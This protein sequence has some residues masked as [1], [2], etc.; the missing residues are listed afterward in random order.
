MGDGQLLRKFH[1]LSSSL[2]ITGTYLLS[3]TT[4]KKLKSNLT[5]Q[6]KAYA[7]DELIQRNASK[8]AIYFTFIYSILEKF[9]ILESANL[10]EH[11]V[12]IVEKDNKKLETSPVLP[13][14]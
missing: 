11:P 10:P 12:I 4:W 8:F 13:S 7:N 1:R 9:L 14:K 6:K 5:S 3:S 2:A